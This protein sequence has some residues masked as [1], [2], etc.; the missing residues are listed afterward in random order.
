MEIGL[1]NSIKRD[2]MDEVRKGT[3]WNK[4]GEGSYEL[5]CWSVS[6]GRDQYV[7]YLLDKF[8][9][10]FDP[11]ILASDDHCLLRTAIQNNYPEIFKMLLH[12]GASM[13]EARDNI[14]SYG[15]AIIKDAY[16][17]FKKERNRLKESQNFVR[18]LDAKRAMKVGIISNA[19]EIV[20]NHIHP[21]EIIPYLNGEKK[22]ENCEVK[23]TPQLNCGVNFFVYDSDKKY[24]MTG[25]LSDIKPIYQYVLYQGKYY[26]LWKGSR[27]NIDESASFIRGLDPKRALEIGLPPKMGEG[28][29]V[30]WRD[31]R[32]KWSIEKFTNPHT[33]EPNLVIVSDDYIDYP[34]LYDDGRIAYDNPYNLPQLV[35][36]KAHKLYLKIKGFNESIDFER[37]KDPR[38]V[39]D[40]GNK[41]YRHNL[42]V[43]KLVKDKFSNITE[44]PKT[45]ASVLAEM[46][47][48]LIAITIKVRQESNTIYGIAWTNS[49]GGMQYRTARTK[50]EYENEIF[51][52]ATGLIRSIE[53]RDKS[54]DESVSFERSG[55]PKKTMR[56]GVAERALEISGVFEQ[57]GEKLSLKTTDKVLQSMDYLV[58]HHYLV[59]YYPDFGGIS[60]YSIGYLTSSAN[61]EYDYIKW[62]DH[63]YKIPKS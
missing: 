15:S 27:V 33:K 43:L 4:Y 46:N 25:F 7:K 49:K 60:S 21:N 5:L 16:E 57:N 28:Y 36:D 14:S 3:Y 12:A 11:Q 6:R 59:H 50:T 41:L 23:L 32:N 31:K 52:L 37:G 54:I 19:V 2:M 8:P 40:I 29:T 39:L 35:K 55:N 48:K 30:L 58:T 34:I 45:Y 17:E 22:P 42:E 62:E 53:D 20:N 26:D 9:D 56:I 1:L 10:D 13:R 18:G 24:I 63:Y 51:S 38:D 47:V 61:T 44:D